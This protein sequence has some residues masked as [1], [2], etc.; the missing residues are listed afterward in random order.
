MNLEAI[1][2]DPKEVDSE[3]PML[4]ES[5]AFLSHGY[6]VIS[7]LFIA[8]GIGPH[9]TI[10]LF[11]GFPGYE[12][13]FDLAHIFRRA[14]YNVLIFHYRGSWGSG[15]SYS[16]GNV[17]ED[18]ETAINLLKSEKCVKSYRVNPE[19]IILIGHSLGGFTAF[20]TAA[21]HPEIKSVAFIAG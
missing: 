1:Y 8:Q 18:A 2:C 4:T 9:P 10:I 3:Y 12:Q 7:S 19:K 15:G 6:N 13:N 14:G 5:F 17:L 21:K 11:H 20:M 16:I